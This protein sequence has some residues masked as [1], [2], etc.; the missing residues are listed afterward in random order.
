MTEAVG[1]AWISSFCPALS[2]PRRLAQSLLSEAARARERAM[3]QAHHRLGRLH[4][5]GYGMFG[6]CLP[7][8]ELYRM[9][10]TSR[11]RSQRTI[12]HAA[13]T[14]A[15][16]AMTTGMKVNQKRTASRRSRAWRFSCSQST[17]AC[18]LSKAR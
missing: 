4:A 17:A 5:R 15:A 12:G 6:T 3:R 8:C 7:C 9:M 10:G 14:A 2:A 16:A 18:C 1:G 13:T 11:F